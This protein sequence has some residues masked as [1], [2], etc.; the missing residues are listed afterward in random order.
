VYLLWRSVQ[1]DITWLR[2]AM[3]VMYDYGYGSQAV[4]HSL[5]CSLTS[6]L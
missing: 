6:T 2:Q 4:V 3:T 1:M 5:L